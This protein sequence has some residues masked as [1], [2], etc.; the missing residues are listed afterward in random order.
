MNRLKKLLYHHK[1]LKLSV[2]KLEK[3][4]HSGQ[5][6]KVIYAARNGTYQIRLRC[7]RLLSD[8]LQG[9]SAKNQLVEMIDDEVELVANAAISL[10]NETKD[11]S[12]ILRIRHARKRMIDRKKALASA[13]NI[14]YSGDANQEFYNPK[15]NLMDQL[16][17][18]QSDFHPPFSF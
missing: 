2:S 12:I 8:H 14:P 16:K 18:H 5:L 4:H 6:E 7:V 11:E 13:R 1:L 3:W 17:R 9:D 15:E 10:F